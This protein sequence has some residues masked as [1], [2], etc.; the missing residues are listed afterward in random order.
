VNLEQLKIDRESSTRRP[1]ASRMPWWTKLLV[2]LA[3][4]GGGA[5]LFQRQI[6]DLADR[7][8]LPQVKT[9]RATMTSASAAARCRGNLRQRLHRRAH[10]RGALGRHARTHHRHERAGG[11]GRQERATSSPACTPTICGGVEARRS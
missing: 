2:L 1:R 9:R 8:R 10:S 7:V 11:L 6:L 4:L 3:V 5:F